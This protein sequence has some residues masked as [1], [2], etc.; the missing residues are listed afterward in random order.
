MTVTLQAPYDLIQASILLPSPNLGDE[1]SPEVK[2]SIRNSM[3]GVIYSTVKT[4]NRFKFTWDLNL[5]NA[6]ARELYVFNE[7]YNS[8]PWRVFDWNDVLYRAY[9]LS[10][11]LQFTFVSRNSV[12]VRLEFEGTKI[13]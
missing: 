12:D 7:Y 8:M 11:P 5:T 4:H 10:N 3:N 9:L 13:V 1:I 2:V 6:K